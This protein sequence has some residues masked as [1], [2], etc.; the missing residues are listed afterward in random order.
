MT[1]PDE[2]RARARRRLAPRREVESASQRLLQYAFEVTDSGGYAGTEVHDGGRRI[3]LYW[4]GPLPEDL[5]ELLQEVRTACDVQVHPALHDA[6]EL[7]R[8]RTRIATSPGFAAS[9]IVTMSVS[10]DGSGLLLGAQDVE[11]SARWLTGLTV[12]VPVRWEQASPPQW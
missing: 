7:R 8:A 1:E 2:D 11:V 6:A 9:G 3:E 10:H 5:R 12:D 4:K